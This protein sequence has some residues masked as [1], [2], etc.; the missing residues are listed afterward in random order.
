MK[1][2]LKIIRLILAEVS[3]FF[4]LG[5]IITVMLGNILAAIGVIIFLASVIALIGGAISVIVCFMEL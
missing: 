5:V 3:A 4:A 1:G 2:L